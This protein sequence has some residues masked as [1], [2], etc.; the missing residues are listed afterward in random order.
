MTLKVQVSINYSQHGRDLTRL[1][2]IPHWYE[3]LQVLASPSRCQPLTWPTWTLKSYLKVHSGSADTWHD[4]TV[5]IWELLP[6]RLDFLVR[7][8]E[9]L[10][11]LG[12]MRFT[13]QFIATFSRQQPELASYSYDELCSVVLCDRPQ[14]RPC[15]WVMGESKLD[16]NA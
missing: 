8:P 10:T 9:H 11:G 4:F 1:P 5:H 15:S 7:N 16:A 2:N 14:C 13:T 6:Y 3:L 12:E